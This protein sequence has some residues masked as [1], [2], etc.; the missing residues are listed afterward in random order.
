MKSQ[1][2]AMGSPLDNLALMEDNDLVCFGDGRESMSVEGAV[3]EHIT[4]YTWNT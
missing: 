2:F 1:K 4:P 3:S